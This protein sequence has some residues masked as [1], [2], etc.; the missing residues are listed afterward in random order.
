MH[1]TCLKL[2]G[3][4]LMKGLE[5]IYF[6]FGTGLKADKIQEIYSVREV[7]EMPLLDM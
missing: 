6:F 2:T 7:R 1:E 5:L 3:A 4:Q